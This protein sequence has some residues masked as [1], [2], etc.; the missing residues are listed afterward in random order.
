[1]THDELIA[2][3]FSTG[4]PPADPPHHQAFLIVVDREDDH[5]WL[6]WCLAELD[7]KQDTASAP[8]DGR[9][10]I[11]HVHNPYSA[12][13]AGLRVR[14]W[15]RLPDLKPERPQPRVERPAKKEQPTNE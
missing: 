7:D 1:M 14:Y 5:G 13:S 4:P 11:V 15:K 10:M 12:E 9:W 6:L 2:E 3:G 8:R